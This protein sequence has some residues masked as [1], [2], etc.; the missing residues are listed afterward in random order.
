M[1][2]KIM[3]WMQGWLL[4]CGLL[5][6][7]SVFAEHLDA[8]L[9][10]RYDGG[11]YNYRNGIYF[12]IPGPLDSTKTMIEK[13]I[14]GEG[15]KGFQWQDRSAALSTMEYYWP[16]I[17]QVNQPALQKA[18]NQK[19]S[20]EASLVLDKALAEGAITPGERTQFQHAIL[21]Q[22]EYKKSDL[23]DVPFFKQHIN[24]WTFARK[25]ESSKV[26][27]SKIVDDFGVIMDVS[28]ILSRG[29][30]TLVWF[31]GTE[32]I[33]TK[34]LRL[35]TC[36][37]GVTCVP[38]PHIKHDKQV[39][40]K[41]SPALEHAINELGANLHALPL[42]EAAS[43]M[44]T[45]DEESINQA[46]NEESINQAPMMAI[47]TAAV[48]DPLIFDLPEDESYSR[49]RGD[50][51][52]R[53]VTLPDGSAL[54]SGYPQT[55][56]LVLKAGK[57]ESQSTAP[58]FPGADDLKL[59]PDGKLWG[60]AFDGAT[61]TSALLSWRL[62]KTKAIMHPLHKIIGCV[63]SRHGLVNRS[64]DDWVVQ[65]GRGV[66]LRADGELFSFSA[67]DNTFT[68]R[69]WNS[70]LRREAVDT[71]QHVMPGVGSRQIQFNDGLFWL[72]DYNGYA[73]SPDTGRVVKTVKT[74]TGGLLFGSLAA[75]WG[76]A[77]TSEGR[78]RVVDL[79]NGL[80]RW[81]LDVPMTKFSGGL[82][83]TAHG[84]LL[85]TTRGSANVAV[86]DMRSGINVAN[87]H[88]PKDVSDAVIAFSWKGDAL[89]MVVGGDARKVMIWNVPEALRDP[90]SGT[91]I[92][93]QRRC[94]Y[95]HDCRG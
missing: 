54:I 34:T 92:P 78:Y 12:L 35:W 89:W 49:R 30:M 64:I 3:S 88:L 59:D 58:Y 76:V 31:G 9:T 80:P 13:S 69:P 24:R 36:M 91:A 48:Q 1:S 81:D 43:I 70:S 72:A 94:T 53:L 75:N 11:N 82:A 79:K 84:R 29:P 47:S 90:A 18:L 5:A 68:Q 15:L 50:Q 83:R 87:I 66:A 2:G 41:I 33:T 62:D 40:D 20:Q 85:A 10:M 52:W 55:H 16:T 4:V 73:I 44:R 21:Q 39:K 95:S 27:S 17:S 26:G 14:D 32:T 25:T 67:K 19:A 56:R 38:F 60:M 77:H 42:A 8:Q 22:R 28:P 71:L 93:D 74:G 61:R 63:H 57:L 37:I 46:P 86:F 45:P 23:K 51:K 65:P 6:S 7:Q